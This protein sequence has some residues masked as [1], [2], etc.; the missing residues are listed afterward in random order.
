MNNRELFCFQGAESVLGDIPAFI[1]RR[2]VIPEEERVA[3]D[4]S[5]KKHGR[6][7]YRKSEVIGGFY[8]FFEGNPCDGTDNRDSFRLGDKY[9]QKIHA[10]FRIILGVTGYQ[11]YLGFMRRVEP[12][13]CQLHPVF[14][15]YSILGIISGKRPDKTYLCLRESYIR[16]R[17]FRWH[18]YR[19]FFNKQLG[20]FHGF[21]NNLLPPTGSQKNRHPQKK[22]VF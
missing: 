17:F 1:I 13:D 12:A 5:L 4:F 14:Y 10:F 18:G 20:N 3:G 9:F 21:N 8:Y 16:A 19:L 15:F 6:S 2:E 11:T 22:Y 7:N